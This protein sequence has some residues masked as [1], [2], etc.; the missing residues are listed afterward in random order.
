[1]CGSGVALTRGFMELS[2]AHERI[3]TAILEAFLEREDS[4]VQFG[5]KVMSTDELRR[6][7]GELRELSRCVENCFLQREKPNPEP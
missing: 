5:F 2:M 7:R 3:E 6:F 1:M 4:L